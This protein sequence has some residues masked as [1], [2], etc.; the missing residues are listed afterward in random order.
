MPDRGLPAVCN[1]KVW[2]R[3]PYLKYL[4]SL[5]IFVAGARFG[6]ANFR[7][8]CLIYRRKHG[9]HPGRQRWPHFRSA[10]RTVDARWAAASQ[11][12][13]WLHSGAERT[14]TN[15]H[16]RPSVASTAANANGPRA[17]STH[18][19]LAIRPAFTSRIGTKRAGSL[20]G[21]YP[22]MTSL[23]SHAPFGCTW[24]AS[25]FG[26]KTAR[27][28]NARCRNFKPHRFKPSWHK[29]CGKR[30]V[31]AQGRSVDGSSHRHQ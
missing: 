28:Q 7:L 3:C 19:H 18:Q 26:A 2:Q 29:T 27:L 11:C 9:K 24:K 16:W 6:R 8:G 22:T 10:L 12:M 1:L 4:N 17:P 23:R 30:Q 21:L 14:R 15:G 20:G 31:R 13:S 25:H 5:N